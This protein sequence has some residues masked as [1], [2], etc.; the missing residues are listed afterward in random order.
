MNYHPDDFVALS[1]QVEQEGGK[2]IADPCNGQVFRLKQPDARGDLRWKRFSTT[3]CGTS[4]RMEL[5]YDA[6]LHIR[7]HDDDDD[8]L[9]IVDHVGEQF[10]GGIVKVCAVDDAIGLW[11]R[12]AGVV[13]SRSYQAP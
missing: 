8:S 6:T 7:I 10:I 9:L 13:S 1:A 4:A 5:D 12:Y 2:L 3:H 11:P